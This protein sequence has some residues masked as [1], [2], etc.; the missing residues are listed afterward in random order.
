MNY[1]T[2]RFALM[3]ALMV[4]CVGRFAAA[5]ETAQPAPV[6]Q[7]PPPQ[8]Q[9]EEVTEPQASVWSSLVTGSFAPAN[10]IT[11]GNNSFRLSPYFK[12][13]YFY[14]SNPANAPDGNAR[15]KESSGWNYTPGL[16]FAYTGNDWGFS[17][18]GYY[19]YDDY[20]EKIFKDEYTFSERGQVYKKSDRW[21]A[22]FTE[23]YWRTKDLG[24]DL[25]ELGGGYSGAG[26]RDNLNVAGALSWDAT[27]KS[28]LAGSVAYSK[29]WYD[30]D[31]YAG[32]S[33]YAFTGEYDHQLTAKTMIIL[34]AGFTIDDRDE[35][36]DYS[37]QYSF[38][39]GL[40]SRLT[41]KVRYR[42]LVGLMYYEYA[43]TTQ[44]APSVS[45]SLTWQIDRK[46]ALSWMANSSFQPSY[47]DAYAN[48]YQL[49][50]ATSL[51]VVYKPTQRIQF[52]LD[53]VAQIYKYEGDWGTAYDDY[54]DSESIRG[55]VSWYANRYVS[56]YASARYYLNNSATPDSDYDSFR[57]DLG[58]TVR[59]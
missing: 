17:L 9:D 15:K 58:L 38:M 47:A 48:G 18:G 11:F 16:D 39:A 33:S 30:D 51:G 53:G 56:V 23:T 22:T 49:T 21:R 8:L 14:D 13:G 31:S 41:E 27:E 12:T 25:A 52:R 4:S 54:S 7:P 20:F 28:S 3:G 50:Y 45:G 57:V 59:Y 34:Q 36:S 46:W 2:I 24:Y 10:G 37:Y 6:P 29:T 26:L 19:S 5:Q 44:V 42:L 35:R 40:G 1:R 32:Y 55:S 43:D